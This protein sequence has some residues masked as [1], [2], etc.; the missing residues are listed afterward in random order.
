[1]SQ[2]LCPKMT[3]VSGRYCY[4]TRPSY[5]QTNEAMEEPLADMHYVCLELYCTDRVPYL[6]V[7]VY[8]ILIQ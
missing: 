7:S 4:A 2:F 3:I 6:S 8:V 5:L 1:V